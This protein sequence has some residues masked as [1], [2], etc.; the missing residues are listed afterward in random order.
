MF[1]TV[2]QKNYRLIDIRNIY[3]VLY[4]GGDK[5]RYLIKRIIFPFDSVDQRRKSISKI[6]K[7]VGNDNIVEHLDSIIPEVV[8]RVTP[9]QWSEIQFQLDLETVYY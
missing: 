2:C 9:E 5:M 4:E 6:K 8:I 3:T 7:I 1:Q